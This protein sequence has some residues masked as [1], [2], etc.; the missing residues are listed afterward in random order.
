MITKCSNKHT[1][2]KNKSSF[3]VLLLWRCAWRCLP[4]WPLWLLAL[5]L[6]TQ[7]PAQL[8]VDCA[9]SSDTSAYC[10]VNV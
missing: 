1:Q 3:S 4:A 5:L 9:L 8:L 2:H 6:S 10:T 7:M